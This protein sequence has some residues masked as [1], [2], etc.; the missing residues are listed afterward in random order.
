[1]P[2]VQGH[3]QNMALSAEITSECACCGQPIVIEVSSDLAYRVLT[4]AARPL[5]SL[6]TVDFDKLGDVSIIHD[7]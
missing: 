2:F 3:L 7:F 6:P 4:E 5:V 1:M